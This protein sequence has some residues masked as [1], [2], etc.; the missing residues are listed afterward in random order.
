METLSKKAKGLTRS[1]IIDDTG[2]PN[3]GSTTRILNELEE[4]GF[5]RKYF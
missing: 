1:E 4:S 5:I 3:A 2:L